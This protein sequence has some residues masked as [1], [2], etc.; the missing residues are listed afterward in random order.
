LGTRK[1]LS[2]NY[3]RTLRSFICGG[4]KTLGSLENGGG[5]VGF[6]VCKSGRLKAF[7]D[8]FVV[9]PKKASS[10][11]Q[12]LKAAANKIILIEKNVFDT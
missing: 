5:I 12:N 7:V 11:G 4:K 2:G 3:R 9:R 6:Q 8:L 1:N 10:D